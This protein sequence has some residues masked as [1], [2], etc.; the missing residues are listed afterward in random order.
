MEEFVI[1]NLFQQDKNKQERNHR[2]K[3]LRNEPQ[4]AGQ[5][6]LVPVQKRGYEKV[7]KAQRL[8]P[9]FACKLENQHCDAQIKQ[10]IQ[11]IRHQ[12][13]FYS[14]FHKISCIC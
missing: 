1:F 7:F 14:A 13:A 6:K 9:E 4:R 5:V 3:K 2:H 12:Q 10:I 8:T 11:K